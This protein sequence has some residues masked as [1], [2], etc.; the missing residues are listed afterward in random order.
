MVEFVDPKEIVELKPIVPDNRDPI[1]TTVNKDQRLNKL[2]Q[3]FLAWAQN[4][5]N[6]IGM[7]RFSPKHELLEY[8][9]VRDLYHDIKHVVDKY[10][11]LGI[12]IWEA[13]DW[14][15]ID[16]N[17]TPK[18]QDIILFKQDKIYV[19]QQSAACR[20]KA[21]AR[22]KKVNSEGNACKCICHQVNEARTQVE[23]DIKLGQL[24]QV[25]QKK[26]DAKKTKKASNKPEA[27]DWALVFKADMLNKD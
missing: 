24:K 4:Q 10:S 18:I 20:V 21:H 3:L 14:R 9:S 27:V 6:E 22:C 8:S 16:R 25:L 17:A 12:A 15:Q 23:G 13:Q 2:E 26:L 1:Y 11:E 19:P 7:L 5:K